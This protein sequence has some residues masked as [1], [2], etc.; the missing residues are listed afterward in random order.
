MVC[1]VP[2]SRRW[3]RNK[4]TTALATKLREYYEL[5]GV[6]PVHTR[7]LSESTLFVATFPEATPTPCSRWLVVQ[8][9]STPP[10]SLLELDARPS[11]VSGPLHAL[12]PSPP[13]APLVS[14]GSALGA[15]GVPTG[16]AAVVPTR[17]T[18]GVLVKDKFPL[19]PSSSHMSA[20][21]NATG[22]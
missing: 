15:N 16:V 14:D 18:T 7:C 9:P 19:T 4:N 6:Y 11:S 1:Q 2:R 8:L 10:P 5:K 13:P 20:G 22:G 12:A 17:V 3:V 21:E